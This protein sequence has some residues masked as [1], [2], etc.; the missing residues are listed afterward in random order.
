[1]L[2]LSLRKTL[3]MKKKIPPK[4]QIPRFHNLKQRS[5]YP[6]QD[7]QIAELQKY[8]TMNETCEYRQPWTRLHLYSEIHQ[9]EKQ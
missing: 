9:E 2:H 1:M 8:S 4:K 5:E 7:P 3:Q 6:F